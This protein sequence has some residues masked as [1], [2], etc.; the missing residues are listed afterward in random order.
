MP[1]PWAGF[2]KPGKTSK[3]GSNSAHSTSISALA[4]KRKFNNKKQKKQKGK[5]I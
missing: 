4:E 2:K 5:N 3:P 1:N